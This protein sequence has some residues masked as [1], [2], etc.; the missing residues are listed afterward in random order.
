MSGARSGG[1]HLQVE[2]VEIHLLPEALGEA[3]TEAVAEVGGRDRPLLELAGRQAGIAE[4]CDAAVRDLVP[5]GRRRDRLACE[6]IE[7]PEDMSSRLFP[8]TQEVRVEPER[9]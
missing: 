3:G 8:G 1:N 2:R 4:L 5:T 6:E 9:R 7:R